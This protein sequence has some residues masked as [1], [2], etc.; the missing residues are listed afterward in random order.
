MSTSHLTLKCI[1]INIGHRKQALHEIAIHLSNRLADVAFIS[2]PP[3]G[4]KNTMRSFPGYVVYQFPSSKPVKAVI[5]IKDNLCSTLG[6]SEFSN[7]N[8]CIVQ[9]SSKSGKKIYLISVYVEPRND[10][11]ST[12][13]KLEFFLQKTS[14]SIHII[15]GDFNAWHTSW[16][17]SKSNHRG[18]TL[19]DLIVSQNLLL[20]NTG[21][22]PTFE[23]VTHG[24]HRESI[25]DLSLVSN[26]TH[27]SIT[28]WKVDF[29]LCPTS[30]HNGITFNAKL[31]KTTLT[32]NKKL[33]TFKYNT[34]NVK[35]DQMKQPFINE[36]N[37][38]LPSF[39]NIKELGPS[40]IEN[41][42]K[43]V[44]TAIQRTC[45]QL[46]PRSSGFVGRAPWWNDHL[47]ELK[48]AAI[49]IHHKLIKQKR[50]KLPLDDILKEK[51]EI[52]KKYY[53]AYC[54]AST[55]HFKEFC[56]RQKKEDVW[57]VTNRLI[58]TKP[59]TQPPATLVCDDGSHTSNSSET[60]QV[61]IDKF[62]PDDTN[63]STDEQRN[64]RIALDDPIFTQSE[65]LFTT[66][67]II[68]CLKSMNHKRAPGPDHLTADIC[69]QFA[70][71]FPYIITDLLNRCLEL[72]YFPEVWKIAYAKIIPKPSKTNYNQ[73]SSFRPIG[74]INVF[75]KLLEKLTMNRLVYFMNRGQN[76]CSGQYGFKQQTS[77]VMA[78]NNALDIINNA[79]SNKEHVIA[80]SLDIKSAFDNAWWPA[81]FQKLRSINCP[82]NIFSLLRNYI[83]NRIVQI[84]FA[85]SSVSK[86]MTRGCI[87]GSVCGP[88][89]WNLLLD[90]LLLSELPS[91]CHL[92]A[93]ADD[94]LLISHSESLTDLENNT[95][96]ALDIITS[97]GNSVKLEFG[98][99]KTQIMGFSNKSLK[100]NIKIH[101]T[102][103]KFVNQIKYLGIIIDRKL[104]FIKHSEYII[105]KAKKLYNKLIT[106]VKPTWGVHPENLKVLYQQVVEP[107]ICYAAGIWS[108]VLKYKHVSK[109]FLSLQRLF[110]IKII[111]GFRTVST[112]ASI[113]LAQLIPLTAK[114]EEVADIETSKLRGISR[115]LPSDVPIE[116]P[117]SPSTMLHPSHRHGISFREINTLK[118]FDDLRLS[119]EWQIYTDGSRHDDCVGAAFVALNPNGSKTV[120]KFKL[121]SSCSV[122]QSELL[123]I[124]KACNWI[125]DNNITRSYI[126]SDC[127]SGLK[128]L[129]N[130]NSYNY[131]A[132]KIH[133]H[134][135]SAR[136]K[137]ISIGF[138]W[139]R[140][141]IGIPG[142]ESAD[143]AAKSAARLHKQPDYLQIPISHVK[144]QNK[145]LS[146]LAAQELYS[147]PNT[148]KHTKNWLPTFEDLSNYLSVIKPY[149]AI[150][151]FLTDHGY[152]KTYLFRFKITT[153]SFCPCDG[154]TP[155]TLDH[156][157]TE[158]PRF[159]RTRTHHTIAS[160]ILN[161]NPYNL[162]EIIRKQTTI[163]TFH[164]HLF[165]IV[166]NLKSFNK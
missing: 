152:H 9:I 57:S 60:A 131:F 13:Q 40:E 122:F 107:I 164:T 43:T 117:A 95:N 134:L 52:R 18:H 27:L 28:D 158:C 8:L 100:C 6:I 19:F 125:I 154:T 92:Q 91:G 65:P 93:Y 146:K 153:N 4:G 106:F 34:T 156:L 66:E 84:N 143:V 51:D 144:Y 46:L 38:H 83:E 75:G 116:S 96:R 151:Q 157:I 41:F 129:C 82:N 165:C 53:E 35:W 121:H 70:I 108:S 72:G 147:N 114:I 68:E 104:N 10:C 118:E 141:H 49:Q 1:Q 62:Y 136:L 24:M 54:N 74:L 37:K 15:C 88:T 50:R 113:S 26:S 44:N 79:R 77:T 126:F 17:S 128:E 140:G 63:D 120:R 145:T 115:F 112:A 161:I 111:Q 30:D 149:F 127:K 23:T 102:L 36:I 56:S 12:L 71:S 67:E 55:E 132:V 42:I 29:D 133:E 76:L 166:K 2:E 73:L 137:N 45:D 47:T 109:K 31:G 159:S 80:V 103:I 110:A 99:D 64:M 33:T 25:I 87:Q 85:D 98:P 86:T 124:E 105:D 162:T 135:H 5:A 81:I 97:W 148:C 22:T 90:E 59:L 7:S 138:L 21:N 32:K 123:S 101:N 3:T 150:T 119:Q 61:L 139:I 11:D 142:N 16:G 155:Q 89:L 14:G 20:C 69:L 48:R 78:I 94:I 130:P 163:D 160:S 58:K 39:V